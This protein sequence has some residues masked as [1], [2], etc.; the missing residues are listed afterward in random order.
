[1]GQKIA[2]GGGGW[3]WGT[4]E[5]VQ[6]PQANTHFT[7]GM[8]SSA[9]RIEEKDAYVHATF[10]IRTSGPKMGS[11]YVTL[12]SKLAFSVPQGLGPDAHPPKGRP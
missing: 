10:A 7:R 4:E 11:L 6:T 9:S 2:L 3:G 12:I 1:M 8:R 5:K